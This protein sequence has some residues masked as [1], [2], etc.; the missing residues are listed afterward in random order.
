MSASSRDHKIIFIKFGFE[1]DLQPTDQLLFRIL[2]TLKKGN[3]Y[4][5]S[6]DNQ[7]QPFAKWEGG[8]ICISM[9]ENYS[10][11]FSLLLQNTGQKYVKEKFNFTHGLMIQSIL[12][13]MAWQHSVST[14]RR[15]RNRNTGYHLALPPSVILGSQPWDSATHVLGDTCLIS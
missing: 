8:D 6:K 1:N 7:Q 11:L 9:P 3:A 14:V 10:R 2:I 15:Q 12:I 4:I 13:R 5:S